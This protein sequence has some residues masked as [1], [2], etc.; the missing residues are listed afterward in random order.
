MFSV[1]NDNVIE[2]NNFF[3]C[4]NQWQ[5]KH[6]SHLK[7]CCFFLFYRIS[8]IKKIFI[9]LFAFCLYYLEVC[10]E[11]LMLFFIPDNNFFSF[12]DSNNTTTFFI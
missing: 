12:F 10:M 11:T 3:R 6:V 8:F 2:W 7:K 5:R 4:R 1:N 9:M